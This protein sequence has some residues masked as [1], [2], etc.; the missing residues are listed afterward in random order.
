MSDA[1]KDLAAAGSV[2]VGLG[3]AATGGYFLK[4]EM[5][6]ATVH[7]MHVYVFAGMIGVGCLLIVPGP[8]VSALTQLGT[9]VGPYLPWLRRGGPAGGNG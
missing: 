7:S 5:A 8:I 3:L 1:K 4:L 6:G 9:A 2:L